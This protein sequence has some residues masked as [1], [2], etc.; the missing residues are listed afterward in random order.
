MIVSIWTALAAALWVLRTC[1]NAQSSL[2]LPLA[3]MFA[4]LA[5]H[6]PGAWVHYSLGDDSGPTPIGM[7]IAAVGAFCFAVGVQISSKLTFGLHVDT[8]NGAVD[9]KFPAYCLIAGWILLGCFVLLSGVPTLSAIISGG[10]MVWMLGPIVGLLQA[11]S[12]KSATQL[13]K[14]TIAAFVYPAMTLIATGFLSA[15][16]TA[17][18]IVFCPL[19]IRAKYYITVVLV[20]V[21]CSWVFVNV[22]V[23]YFHV[24]DQIRAA[25]WT[26]ASL[27][28]R[29][30]AIESAFASY[31]AFSL[32]NP[33]HV[34]AIDKR[35]NQNQF[36]GIAAERIRDGVGGFLFGETIWDAVLS[37]VPRAVWQGKPLTGGSGDIVRRMTGLPLSLKAAWGVGHVMEL[38]VNFGLVG[39]SVGFCLLG[40][41]LATLDRMAAESLRVHEYGKLIVYFLPAA[42]L[43]FPEGSMA[44]MVGG[45]GAAL[46]MSLG[47]K[48]AWLI[49]QGQEPSSGISHESQAKAKS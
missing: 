39:V 40:W 22:F 38:Y 29:I 5:I 1:R 43:I 28:T 21:C 45:S 32:D 8:P 31:E 17:M 47:L 3:Y 36:L 41:V 11:S 9:K 25:V 18:F 49:V 20:S 13:T 46:V 24:R 42:A 4:L 34:S 27:E 12:Q 37:I 44:E 48:H 14:W 30:D 2:A 33:E 10:A 26:G 7:Y 15:A 35:L 19:A 6:L 16:S 23:N